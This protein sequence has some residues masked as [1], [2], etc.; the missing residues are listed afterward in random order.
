MFN[1]N[2]SSISA[3]LWRAD[4]EEPIS[5]VLLRYINGIQRANFWILPF[6]SCLT[7]KLIGSP[8]RSN[9][10][11]AYHIFSAREI[12]RLSTGIFRKYPSQT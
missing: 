6:V 10:N 8:K 3:I 1:A 5:Q 2:I 7:N 12:V 9:C 11:V 4:A